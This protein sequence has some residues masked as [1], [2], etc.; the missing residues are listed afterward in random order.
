MT[1]SLCSTCKIQP[2]IQQLYFYF[3]C[4]ISSGG[5]RGTASLRIHLVSEA[6]FFFLPSLTFP[7]YSFCFSG[8][9]FPVLFFFLL[10]FVFRFI[11]V[12]GVRACLT[13]YDGMASHCLLPL[14]P[15]D[16]GTR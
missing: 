1:G 8:Y 16:V 6:C 13:Q 4:R 12:A 11:W 10:F 14:Q 9:F 15:H 3:A 7:C 5:A 2:Y